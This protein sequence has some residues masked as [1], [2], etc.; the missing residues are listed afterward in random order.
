[1]GIFMTQLKEIFDAGKN[2]AEQIQNNDFEIIQIISHIDADGLTAASIASIALNREGIKSKIKFVKQ[3]DDEVIQD[4]NS[5][6]DRSNDMD[7]LFWFTDLG[8]GMNKQIQHLKPII[9]DHHAP[10]VLDYDVPKQARTDLLQFGE[11]LDHQKEERHLNPHLF[12]YDGTYEISGAGTVY[13][14]ARALN[15]KNIDLSCLAIIG[16]VGDLQDSKY[17]QL[18]GLN[19][20]ILSD[21]I[22]SNKIITKLDFS[23]FGRETRPIHNIIQY[24]TDPYLPGLTMNEANCIKF[25]EQLKV[26]L[27]ENGRFRHWVELT[28]DERRNILS[29]LMELLLKKGI[30][31]KDAKRLLGEVY[32]LPEEQP[33]TPLHDAKEFAT[34][35]NSCGKYNRPEVGFE[36]CK[37]DRD[38]YLNIALGL[39]KCHKGTI[40]ESM[41]YVRELGVKEFGIIQYFH[42]QDKI[43]DN[44]V[45]TIASMMLSNNQIDQDKTVF[46]F[47]LTEDG[48]NL[49]VSARAT[50]KLVEQGL[51]L[52]EV[53]SQVSSELGANSVGGG[54]DIAAGATIPLDKQEKFLELAEKIVR[55]QLKK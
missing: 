1:M 16:A 45:G 10:S 31:N 47:A 37:G 15:N 38:K 26:P 21:A 36:I 6:N 17:H 22:K 33:G 51:D 18:V 34:L 7:V 35:L 20:K 55:S 13:L 25:L 9:T 50:R 41:Q 5:I 48:K 46:G 12:N 28:L 24:S 3:L 44:I 53:M 40:M 27:K 2:I 54:H 39:L 49:K 52:S 11:V 19:K 4:L 43:P 42:A 8:S 29:E 32:I 23:T 30:G 14:V